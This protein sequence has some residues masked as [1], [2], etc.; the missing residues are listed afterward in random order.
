MTRLFTQSFEALRFAWIALVGNRLRTFLSLLGITI[1]ILAIIS[2][3]A[4]VD[5][6]EK[7]IRNSVEGLGSD[8]VYVQKWPWGGG[9]EEYAWWKYFQ[10]KDVD[11]D[12]FMQL[13]ARGVA[14]ASD[15]VLLNGSNGTI[16]HDNS[17]VENAQ[18]RGVSHGYARLNALDISAGRYFSTLESRN[19]RSIC[20]LGAD[21]ADALFLN[22]DPVGKKVKAF[23]REYLVLGVIKRQGASLVGENSD[24]M[25]M[26]P[27]VNLIRII[28]KRSEG[29]AIQIKVKKGLE[30]AALK[31]DIRM[32]MRA[33]RR[34]R[35]RA[36]D[37]FS[38]N[39]SSTLSSGLDSMFSV[40]GALGTVIGGFSILVGG[41]GI[42][43]IMFV[44]VRER[45]G[46]IGI[47][48]A[49]GATKYFVL[50]QFLFESIMLSLVG[51]V[52]GILL[53]A[54]LM[55]LG[56]MATGFALVLST[57]NV[58]TGLLISVAIGIIAGIAPAIVAANME[59]VDAIR[60]NQ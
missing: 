26:V 49:L 52:A 16:T 44:S 60:F 47:Q 8:V 1:G 53:V 55:W 50:S 43:N 59:P 7:S 15:I 6:L 33:I 58:I 17:N 21:I 34:L 18:I 31:E 56:S 14:S 20:L 45:T 57:A 2:V 46:Q 27:A 13:T 19:G 36:D 5:S 48:K 3:Y 25:M 4:I 22:E 40:I 24:E 29:S 12:D 35:P 42:A 37:D 10:R 9:G 41:F 51:G 38:L 32:Q 39:D 28:G 23:G 11:Y 54:L 30:L